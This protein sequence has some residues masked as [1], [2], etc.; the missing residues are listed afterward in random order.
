MK[1][2]LEVVMKVV[3]DVLVGEEVDE[4][5]PEEQ[6][7]MRWLVNWLRWTLRWRLFFDNHWGDVGGGG[8]RDDGW[9][10]RRRG[11]G[12]YRGIDKEVDKMTHHQR[13]Q[14][15]HRSIISKSYKGCNLGRV[16]FLFVWLTLCHWWAKQDHLN[17]PVKYFIEHKLP[18]LF[19]TVI[20]FAN[21]F[22]F[23]K[24]H[25]K[26]TVAKLVHFFGS[27]LPKLKVLIAIHWCF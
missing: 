20:S 5:M 14:D 16:Y 1:M 8:G 6:S 11:G 4:D 3:V 7:G 19:L 27:E 26:I 9:E 2:M 18:N 23:L 25:F 15:S 10:G 21:T 17:Y 12:G 13:Y 24:T 22:T